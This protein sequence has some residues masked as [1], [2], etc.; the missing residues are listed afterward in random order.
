MPLLAIPVLGSFYLDEVIAVLLAV[1]VFF[2]T[3]DA[4][5]DDTVESAMSAQSKSNHKEFERYRVFDADKVSQKDIMRTIEEIKTR[6]LGNEQSSILRD[7]G[8]RCPYCGAES[9]HINWCPHYR[10]GQ[11]DDPTRVC[12]LKCSTPIL[13]ATAARNEGLCAPC[14]KKTL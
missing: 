5:M 3:A 11:K 8:G 6:Q 2:I 12:C 7:R 4:L 10:E 9:G 13:L 1:C 14:K